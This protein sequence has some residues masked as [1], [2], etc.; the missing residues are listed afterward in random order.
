MNLNNLLLRNSA[1]EN[2]ILD[3]SV[4]KNLTADLGKRS[5]SATGSTSSLKKGL[6]YKDE[7]KNEANNTDKD[8]PNMAYFKQMLKKLNLVNNAFDIDS[9]NKNVPFHIVDNSD[10]TNNED[11][12]DEENVDVSS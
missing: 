5:D 11:Q 10:K 12:I 9:Q 2:I 8:R 6:V 7:I 4:I 3:S 1:S